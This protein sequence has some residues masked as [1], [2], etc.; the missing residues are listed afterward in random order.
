MLDEQVAGNKL[1]SYLIFLLVPGL[2][3][4]LIYVFGRIFFPGLLFGSLIAGI[5]FSLIYVLASYYS[6]DEL[7]LKVVKARPANPKEHKYIINTVEGLCI[8][9]GIPKPEIYIQDSPDIN[10]FATGR[11]PKDGKI[12]V[13][14][15]AI[16]HLT[17]EELEGVLAHELAHIKNYDILFMSVVVML[18]GIISIMSEILLRGA[19]FGGHKDNDRNGGNVL[20]I[21][22]GIILAILAPI[23]A[24]LV[25]LA[26]SRQREYLADS[27]GSLLSRNPEGLAKALEKIK[28]QNTGQMHV[29]KAVAPLYIANPFDAKSIA[30]LFSTHP[31]LDE[32]IRRLRER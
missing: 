20:F 4:L 23:V 12:C 8:A 13:T 26:I 19:F 18:I 29:N 24:R 6:S 30:T 16:E 5:V 1:K 10:A 32:R 2:I 9:A 31:S 11:N 7:I 14:T 15:G 22:L 28:K 27:S 21:V 25:Q 3:V 17:R